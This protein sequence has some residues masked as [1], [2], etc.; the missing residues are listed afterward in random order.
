MAGFGLL[1]TQR[2]LVELFAGGP[3]PDRVAAALPALVALAA[4]T[5]IRGAFGIATGYAQNGL[6]PRVDREI[7]RRLFETT[8]AVRLDAFDAGRV[9]RRHGAGRQRHRVGDRSRPGHDGPVGRGG[10]TGGGHVGRHRDPPVAAGRPARGD[11]AAGLGVAAGRASAVPDLRDRVG[12]T[13]STVDRAPPHD[14]AQRRDRAAQLRPAAVPARPVRPGDGRRDPHPAGP[15]PPD[16][17][18]DLGGVGDRRPDHRGG[19][20]AA[21]AVAPRWTDPAVGR[22]HLCDRDP[23]GPAVAVHRHLPDRRDLQR[24]PAL[25]RLHRVHDAR[26]EP[27]ARR[28]RHRRPRPADPGHGTGGQPAL[29]GPGDAGRTRRQPDHPVRADGRLRGG[30]R[31][32]QDNPG[33]DDRRPARARRR[34]GQLERPTTVHSGCPRAAAAD[35]G[36][37][38]GL[39]P[40]AVHRR[41]QHR[42]RG[43]QRRPGPGPDR[44]GRPAARSPTT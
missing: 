13:P 11:P 42:H 17:D 15:G 12:A 43:H 1:A 20:P 44:G 22:R 27:P 9:R 34:R 10:R 28:V 40:V 24:R 3:T 21:R 23:G 2:V 37:D 16:D 36:G 6:T 5:G 29:P 35:R 39:P 38:A 25:Q 30:E 26:R 19:L 41:D 32:G 14:R 31:V 4:A 33:R 7:Q 18:H 8:T